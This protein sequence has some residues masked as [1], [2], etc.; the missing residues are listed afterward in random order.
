MHFTSG[1]YFAFLIAVFFAYWLV[2]GRLRLRIAF[3]ATASC[4]FY[5]LV[6]G[7]ALALLFAISIIDFTTTRLMARCEDRTRRKLLLTVSLSIDIGALCFFKYANFFMESV[8]DG[9]SIFGVAIATSSLNLLVP[10]GISFFIFQ[11]LAYVIDVYR[12]DADPAPGYQDYLAFVSFFPTIVAGPILRAKQLLPRLRD[13][14]TLDA[15]KGGQALFLIAVGLIKKIAIADY[16]SANFVDRVFDFPERFSSLEVMTAVYGYALQIYA[17][18]SGYSDIAIGS[19]LLLGFT[20]PD[21]F[22]APYRAKDLPEFWRRWH[23]TLST[24]LR[25]YVFFTVVGKRAR[26]AAALYCGLVVTM[27]IGGLWHGAAWTFALWG[28]AHGLG[29]AAA[30]AFASLKKRFQFPASEG[31]LWPR[32]LSVF[33]TFH[34]VCFAWILFRADTLDKALSVF[35]QLLAFTADTTNLAL[36]VALLILLGF[37]AHWTPDRVWSAARTGFVRL[38][39]LAQA[40]ALVLLAMGLYSVASSDVA[41]FIYSR[42]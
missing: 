30:R 34:F 5:A 27:L 11:S 9:L 22:N 23:I 42:F 40:C 19:A 25:D 1:T 2:A 3:L 33:I 31:F 28:L 8:A 21:N 12:K 17:D 38:P 10:V 26:S 29:L 32:V 16:L 36:P 4:L 20:L 13:R 6:G 37:I 14:L 15:A 39:A 7:Q 18:F 24:W 35:G 41:P